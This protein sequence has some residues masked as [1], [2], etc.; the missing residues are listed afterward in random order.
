M[1]RLRMLPGNFHSAQKNLMYLEKNGIQ[2]Y[3][4][5][6]DHEKWNTRVYKEEIG[7]KQGHEDQRTMGKTERRIQCEHPE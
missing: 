4:K 3:I 5:L 6:Q 7:S 2:S 1:N